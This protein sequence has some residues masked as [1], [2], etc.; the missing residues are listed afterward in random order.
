MSAICGEAKDPAAPRQSDLCGMARCSER[1]D[2]DAAVAL[3]SP[4][5]DQAELPHQ[6]LLPRPPGLGVRG[7]CQL[8]LPH[9]VPDPRP[10]R[11]AGQPGA[12]TDPLPSHM[13]RTSAPVK[14]AETRRRTASSR[15]IIPIVPSPSGQS[16]CSSASTAARSFLIS[17]AVAVGLLRTISAIT[18]GPAAVNSLF[19]T[20]RSSPS[21]LSAKVRWSSRPARCA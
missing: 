3:G 5:P 6:R 2:L 16:R 20:A 19:R 17:A 21:C 11:V 8:Q 15:T 12:M 9:D 18:S 7:S 1:L 10:R 4:V 14:L 13:S